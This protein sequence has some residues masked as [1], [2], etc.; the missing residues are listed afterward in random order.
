MKVVLARPEHE[1]LFQDMVALM[2]KHE[3]AMTGLEMLAVGANMIG[4]LAALQDQRAIT[5]AYALEVIAANLEHG[6]KTVI[7][8]LA[9]T[10]GPKQ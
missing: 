8:T 2:R 5:P 7:D 9:A 3:R 4:K 1:V 10:T 6:N